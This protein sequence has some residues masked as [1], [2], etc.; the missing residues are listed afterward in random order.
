MWPDS[1]TRHHP[2]VIVLRFATTVLAVILAL[3]ALA[4]EAPQF[5]IRIENHR[6]VPAELIVP[7]GQ[8]M[9]LV[10]ENRDDSAE[11]FESYELNREKIVGPKLSRSEERRVGKECVSTCR[12]RGSPYHKKKKKNN[13]K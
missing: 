6:F 13:N 2:E 7:A 1:V 3:P 8:K 4:A 11:E 12:S 5:T 9:K 10:I